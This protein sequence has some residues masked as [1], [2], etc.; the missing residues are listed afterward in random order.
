VAWPPK[1]VPY[2][3]LPAKSSQTP[4]SDTNPSWDFSSEKKDTS[5]SQLRPYADPVIINNTTAKPEDLIKVH[6]G[7]VGTSMDLL[8]RL[9][10]TLRVGRMSRAETIIQRLAQASPPNSPEVVHAH[11]AYLEELLRHLAAADHATR[12][13]YQLKMQKWFEVEVY[14]NN[15]QPDEKMLVIMVRAAIRGLQGSRRD[16]AIRRYV[17]MA[18]Q[19]GDSEYDEVLSSEDYDDNEFTILGAATSEFYEESK[20]QEEETSANSDIPELNMTQFR[21]LDTVSADELPDIVATEQKGEGLESVKKALVAFARLPALPADAPIEAQRIRAYERQRIIEETSVDVAVDKWRKENEELQKIGVSSALQ[22]KPMG[23]L[24]WQWYSALLPVLEEELA[25][26]KKIQHDGSYTRSRDSQMDRITYAPYLELMPIRKIA[27]NTVLHTMGLVT[28]GKN[29]S[30]DKWDHEIKLA[31][32]ITGLGNAIEEECAI[33]VTKRQR[34]DAQ[35]KANNAKRRATMAK[36]GRGNQPTE[37]TQVQPAS[38]DMGQSTRTKKSQMKTF[39]N[40]PTDV[41]A[42]MGAMLASKLIETAHFPVTREHPRTREKITQMQPAFTHRMKYMNG[43][44]I[45]MVQPNSALIRKVESEP[46]GALLAKR[47]PMIVEPRP[48]TSWSEGGYLQYPTPIVRLPVSDTSGK[49]YFQA[50]DSKGDTKQVYAGLN[51]LSKVPWKINQDVLKVQLHAWNSGEQVANLAPLN[52]SFKLPQEPEPSTDPLPR[53]RWLQ[54]V[55]EIEDKKTGLHSQRCFQNLQ[56]EIAKAM[57]NETLYFPHNVDFR[58]RAYPIPPY[59]N[60]MGADN[61][62]GLLVFGQ[63]K[64]LGE[65]GLRWLKIH[66]ANV[67][68]YDK[69]SLQE[70]ENYTMQHLDDIYDSARNPL[71]GRRWWLESED[72]WQTLAACFELTK[73]LDSPDPTKFVSHLP[74]HQDGTCNGLQHYAALGGD[75]AGAAQVNLEPG[76]KPADIYTAVANAVNEE[77]ERDAEAGNPI[78]KML[79]G[80][81][82]RKV[83]KQPVMTNVYGVTFFGAK[84]QVKKQLLD[85]FP[86]LPRYAAVNPGNLSHYVAT[87]IF[88][89]L[90]NMFTGAQ[91]IQVWLGVCADRIST[92]LSSEQIEQ[93]TMETNAKEKASAEAKEVVEAKKAAKK[94]AAEAEKLAM[95]A[96]LKEAKKQAKK[97]KSSKSKKEAAAEVSEAEVSEGQKE[98]AIEDEEAE[99]LLSTEDAAVEEKD[100][101]IFQPNRDKTMTLSKPLFKSSVTWTTPLRMPVVQP[102]RSSGTRIISTNLQNITLQEP[103]VWDPVSKRKQ[104][105]AFPP[106]FIHSLDA[107]HMMLSALKCNE[108]GL[109]FASIHDSF[110]THAC[111]VEK[112]SEVLRDAF[113]AMHSEDI[114]GRLREEFVTRYKNHMYLAT[115]MTN[116]KVGQKIVALRKTYK[117]KTGQAS[118]LALEKR[119]LD[120]LASADAEDR[121]KGAAMLTP[122]SIVA[123]EADK[124]AF[125]LEPE[126][127]SQTLGE[128]PKDANT[129]AAE[130]ESKAAE[131]GPVDDEDYVGKEIYE[132][133][134]ANHKRRLLERKLYIWLPMEFPEVPEKGDFDVK[135]LKLSKYFF[136]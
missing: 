58:G 4:S 116:S 75:K 16:R 19:L 100:E 27:A 18:S 48:W 7:V 67:A 128:I 122:G 23:A 112:M 113:V 107:T 17:E 29:R 59:L 76:D 65:G 124:S 102:Y 46:M 115:V 86:D 126:I 25:L 30:T 69:A 106:N 88:K 109:T 32:L 101:K 42:K 56:L 68:G 99:P 72:A 70:R 85:I 119:R 9:Y 136:H 87:K 78:A 50:A 117:G 114:V 91:A 133:K 31:H 73:A 22:T 103:Q 61:A 14:R 21:R 131:G 1:H 130:A 24:M 49:D 55:R 36:P 93:L 66:L 83:V 43:R 77:V 57:A 41:K 39:L 62:R 125:V 40:W 47:M 92:C 12:P 51:A 6:S 71:G 53:R 95:K 38:E 34:S 63:G 96:A 45:G 97:A 26:C 110:W 134:L 64:E 123:S 28:K 127:Q 81:I 84:A 79:Q 129:V 60:H 120:L 33:E 2:S 118:E 80:H 94:A 105:Q 108:I 37:F 74:T 10:T 35:R 8:Q 90:G 20:E 13:S 54:E 11:T 15:V 132:R 89:S 98:A 44:K 104:L 3:G 82:S 52:P 111:D 5:L 135:R 121:A